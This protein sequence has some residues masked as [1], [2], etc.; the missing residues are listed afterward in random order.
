MLTVSKNVLKSKML[1]YFRRVQD[2]GEELL[3]THNN[4]PVAK[5]VPLKKAKPV[6]E[7]FGDLRRKA[8][9]RGDLTEP[10]TSEWGD[11]LP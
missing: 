3:V 6:E 7:V 11:N 4:V 10:T 5:V 8:K 9:L 2:D 1:E